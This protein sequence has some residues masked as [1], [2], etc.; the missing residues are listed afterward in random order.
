MNIRPWFVV[1]TY[2][3]YLVGALVVCVVVAVASCWRVTK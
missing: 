3:I 1:L 2:P